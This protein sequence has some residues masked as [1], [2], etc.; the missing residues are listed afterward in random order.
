MSIARALASANGAELLICDCE[1]ATASARVEVGI[2]ARAMLIRA[3]DRR[4]VRAEAIAEVD[5]DLL[6]YRAGG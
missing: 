4:M 2:R 1:Y 5:A 6:S 3:W